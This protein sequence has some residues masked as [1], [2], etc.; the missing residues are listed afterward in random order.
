MG[1]LLR[2]L[3]GRLRWVCFAKRLTAKG[4]NWGLQAPDVAWRTDVLALVSLD[5]RAGVAGL[6][7]EDCSDEPAVAA[8]QV[9]AVAPELGHGQLRFLGFDGPALVQLLGG[10]VIGLIA[11]DSSY[12]HVNLGSRRFFLNQ[13]WGIWCILASLAVVA[14]DAQLATRSR[15]RAAHEAA[16]ERDR[17]AEERE[18]QAEDAERQRQGI[19]LL[20]GAAL[21]SARVQ[22][23]PSELNRSRLSAFLA[24]LAEQALL[25]QP[26]PES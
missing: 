19:A 4:R 1:H 9:A 2:L 7:S 20:R 18:R 6:G 25:D 8:G 21:L 10:L 23:D 5:S 13:Q 12:D 14:V 11:L 22:L 15:L 3:P 16:E 24:F 26:E 17:A